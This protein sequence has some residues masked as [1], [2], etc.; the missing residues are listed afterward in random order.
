MEVDACWRGRTRLWWSQIAW[1]MFILEVISFIDDDTWPIMLTAHLNWAES[2]LPV[3][4]ILAQ[5][6]V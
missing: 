2:N 6:T 4:K 3:A 1:R 5:A